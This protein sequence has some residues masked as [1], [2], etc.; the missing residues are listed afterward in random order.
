MNASENTVMLQIEK[1][2][3]EIKTALLGS[4]LSGDEGLVG[5][6][7]QV[8]LRQDLQDKKIEALN[9]DKIKNGVYI[10]IIISLASM[11]AVGFVGLIFNYFSK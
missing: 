7:R 4:A 5:K 10:R 9:D 3:A 11:L 6:I 2:I 1:D 8:G